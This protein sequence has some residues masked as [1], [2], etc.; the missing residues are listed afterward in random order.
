M[1]EVP[2][3]RSD[4]D[5]EEVGAEPSVPAKKSRHIKSWVLIKR[6][7]EQEAEEFVNDEKTWSR[8]YTRDSEEGQKR[9][10]R[11]N[12]VKS[13]GPQCD[14]ALYLL[15][16][17]DCED[18]LIFKTTSEH[19]HD[20]IGT[21]S[22]YGISEN[23]KREINKLFDLRLKPKA[24]LEAL[25]KIEGIKVPSKRQLNN[26]LYDRRREKY[27]RATIYLGELEK[28]IFDRTTIP[29]DENEVF[30]FSY[31]VLE[32]K[33]PTF[34]LALSTKKLLNIVCSTD[35]LHIDATY[36]LIWQGFPVLVLGT[37][38]KNRKFHPLCLGISTNERQEDFQMIFGGLKEKA[39]SL[40]DHILEPR[41]LV[42]DAAQ[43]II[44]AFIEVFG[45]APVVRMCWAHAKKNMQQK[46]QKTVHKTKQKEIIQDID[47]LHYAT[48]YE[49]FN[50]AS[51]AFVEKWQ[52]QTEFVNYFQE[53]WLKKHPNWF[54]GAAPCSPVTNNALEA[55]NRNIKDHN[56]LRERFPLSHFLAIATEMVGQWSIQS[57]KESLPEEPTI[58][59]KDWTDGYCWAKKDL[60]IKILS[61]N[62]AYTEY[63]IPSSQV[64]DV[65]YGEQ[66]L[67]FD[68]YK[69]KH[70]AFWKVKVPK[71]GTENVNWKKGSCTCPQFYKKYICKHLLGLAIRLKLATPPSEA[72]ALP[73][74]QKR[75]RGRPTKSRP[76]LII[77]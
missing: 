18:V 37:T 4:S 71:N 68:D 47:T 16:V 24:I 19:N 41:V 60:K 26:Y 13:K 44:N 31:Y 65:N 42:C 20:Q 64:G 72:K 54:L 61:S 22:D 7:S 45:N 70:F 36:K 74:G 1:D 73:I 9:F 32:D 25:N 66:W 39:L 77:Q 29:D 53:E 56:T 62:T 52:T 27:G 28:W 48:S 10:Y 8:N 12:K 50:A 30:V 6:C 51:Q 5:E 40:F 17:N 63:L 57:C 11:C 67:N 14:C 35:V 2:V 34:R 38:D 15:F 49:V 21:R 23:V 58:E 55:F 59:L 43:A 76:A 75:K 33:V 3:Y 46:V 69:R